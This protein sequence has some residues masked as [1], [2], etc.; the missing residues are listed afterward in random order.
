MTKDEKYIN[1]IKRENRKNE[2]I[3]K[4]EEDS[5]QNKQKKTLA[6]TISHKHEETTQERHQKNRT[7]NKYLK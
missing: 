2:R 5:K 7:K 3:M 4:R 1:T 6:E